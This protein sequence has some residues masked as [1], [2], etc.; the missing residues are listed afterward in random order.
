MVKLSRRCSLAVIVTS[1]LLAGCSASPERPARQA[2]RVF[3]SCQVGPTEN[4][5]FGTA[6]ADDPARRIVAAH[7]GMLLYAMS[8]PFWACG[9]TPQEGLR[10]VHSTTF[11]PDVVAVR[12]SHESGRVEVGSVTVSRRM[13]GSWPETQRMSKGT[14]ANEWQEL[15]TKVESLDLWSLP[16]HQREEASVDGETWIL[17]IRTGGRYH[18]VLRRVLEPGVR[19][20]ARTLFLLAG[21]ELPDTLR[22]A[23]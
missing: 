4:P 20:V 9:S 15:M 2:D 12:I 19:D 18:V 1:L 6:F 5:Y 16:A 8:E 17:E 22:Q 14:S 7:F 11:A 10:V 23:R 21:A 3:S 13:D